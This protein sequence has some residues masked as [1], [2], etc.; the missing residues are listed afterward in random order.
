MEMYH[1]HEGGIEKY[2]PRII[3]TYQEAYRVMRAADYYILVE[4]FFIFALHL[5]HM[6]HG[7]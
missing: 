7:I 4:Y 3:D 1:G 6:S 5:I 2:V